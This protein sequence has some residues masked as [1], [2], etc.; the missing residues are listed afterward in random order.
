VPPLHP[1]V[2][3]SAALAL[4]LVAVP[5]AQAQVTL[6]PDGRWRYLLSAGGNATSGNSDVLAVNLAGEAARV[7]ER[8]KWTWIGQA[9]YGKTNGARTANRSFLATQYNRDISRNSFTFAAADMLRDRPA[10]I[11]YRYSGAGGVGRHMLRSED[12][13]VD[14]SLGL[15]YTQDNY[16]TARNV[17]GRVRDRYGRI[18]GVLAEESTHRLTDT[19]N[20]RQRL[21]LFPNLSDGGYWRATFDTG[22]TVAITT[23]MTTTRGPG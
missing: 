1:A 21:T 2:V 16:V 18:E 4:L 9:A 15:A 13:N 11:A 8:D 3:R 7:T 14:L 6:K 12:H 10:N 17:H 22:L 20:L 23:T 19:T 5:A